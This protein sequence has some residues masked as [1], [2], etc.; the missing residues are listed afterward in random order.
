MLT[1]T[2]LVAAATLALCVQA[3]MVTQPSNDT[4]WTSTGQQQI[5]WTVRLLFTSHTS[6]YTDFLFIV[7]GRYR[8]NFSYHP[9]LRPILAKRP[10]YH[11]QICLDELELILLQS[12]SSTYSE[13]WMEDQFCF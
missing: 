2:L 1:Y 7:V 6:H 13:W 12:E 11:R 9:A 5:T 8:P 10:N 3:I 4:G